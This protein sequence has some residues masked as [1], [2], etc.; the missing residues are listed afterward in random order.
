MQND[1]ELSSYIEQQK[2]TRKKRVFAVEWKGRKV[3]V[4]Q[5]EQHIQSVWHK[6]GDVV[7]SI[8]SNPLFTST[9]SEGGVAALKD[10][11]R[12]LQA[13]RAKGVAVP[14]VLASGDDWFAIE[15]AGIALHHILQGKQHKYSASEQQEILQQAAYALAKLHHNGRWHGRPALRDILWNGFNIVFIDFEEDLAAKIN[16]LDCMVRD[17]FLLIHGLYRYLPEDSTLVMDVW[18]TYQRNAPRDVW[19]A[20]C[21][22]AGRMGWI[23]QAARLL[24]GVGG[25]DVKQTY[26]TLKFLRKQAE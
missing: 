10:E 21:H 16:P 11:I 18:R 3:W 2:Q 8:T 25:H 19:L 9:V 4:K 6:L 5:S 14:A 22:L 12:R 20:T 7:A 23:F 17:L 24:K 26:A 15:D 1:M 13:L